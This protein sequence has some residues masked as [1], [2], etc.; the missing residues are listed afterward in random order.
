MSKS[1]LFN[2]LLICLVNICFSQKSIGTYSLSY[3]NKQYEIEAS[4]IKNEKF[5]IYIQVG[6]QKDYTKAM[7]EVKNSDLE[8]FNQ[9]LLQMKDKYVEWSDVAKKNDVKDMTKEMDF[10]SPSVTICW[11]SSKWWFSYGH[12]LQPSFLILDNGKMVVS[13]YKKA[14]ASSNQYIDEKIY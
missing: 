1:A 13:I 4:E 9:F 12:K 2:I 7:I 3:F 5:S 6:V 8:D 10:K 11:S 14:T